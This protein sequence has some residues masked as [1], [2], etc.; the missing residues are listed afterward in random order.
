LGKVPAEYVA[1]FEQCVAELGDNTQSVGMV[2]NYPVYADPANGII[3]AAVCGASGVAIRLP[4]YFAGKIIKDG[5]KDHLAYSGGEK[6]L[7]ARFSQ[8][9]TAWVLTDGGQNLAD[10][11]RGLSAAKSM[12]A[13]ENATIVARKA[14]ASA[15]DVNHP[16][17]ASVLAYLK[18]LNATVGS[19]SPDVST[20]VLE[21][22][23]QQAHIKLVRKIVENV[24]TMIH[25][26]TSIIF[27]CYHNERLYLRLAELPSAETITGVS[28]IPE[29][30]SGWITLPAFTPQN[31]IAPLLA[32]AY[33][34]ASKK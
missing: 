3:F 34:S 33:Q 24:M 22:L 14:A 2:N 20:Y 4:T 26:D 19:P 17:N 6:Q 28:P 13:A 16:E 12:L 32:S 5:A 9:S 8:D 23:P 29:V 21:T 18:G 27:A 30:G 1:F 25:P 15:V 31:V 10:I 11:R 7:V